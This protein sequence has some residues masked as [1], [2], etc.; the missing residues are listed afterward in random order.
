MGNK[1][2]KAEK[3]EELVESQPVRQD[4]E[5]AVSSGYDK[6]LKRDLISL[7]ESRD[8]EIAEMSGIAENAKRKYN[9]LCEK[10]QKL[11]HEYDCV[12][13]DNKL[14]CDRN[15]ELEDAIKLL[16][17]K[18][19]GYKYR[20]ENGDESNK[21]LID[22]LNHQLEVAKNVNNGM[23]EKHK[24]EI[25]E[26]ESYI[27]DLELKVSEMTELLNRPWWKRIF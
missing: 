3:K 9:H 25:A 20:I 19:A 7:L 13:Q 26:R 2:E 6:L 17:A 11:E 23:V 8:E 16:Q 21:A 18:I 15:V 14:V 27:Y 12:V 24:S 4:V 1:K 22:E 10:F 5:N